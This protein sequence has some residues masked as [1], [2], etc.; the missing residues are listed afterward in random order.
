MD[1]DVRFTFIEKYINEM[2]LLSWAGTGHCP[3]LLFSSK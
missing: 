3:S 2:A 1:G